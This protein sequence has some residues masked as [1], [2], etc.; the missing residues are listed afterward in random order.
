MN[1]DHSSSHT[2]PVAKKPYSA[3]QVTDLGAIGE[4]ALGGSGIIGEAMKGGPNMMKHP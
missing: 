4:L 1:S 3:P 2:E